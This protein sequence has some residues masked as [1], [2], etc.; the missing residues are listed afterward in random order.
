M[1]SHALYTSLL[2][3]PIIHILRAAGFH[4][5]RP[6]VLDTLVDLAARYLTVL[7]S[8]TAAHAYTNHNEL[9]PTITD[10]RMALQDVG[11]LWP[12][13]TLLEED[14]AGQEDMRG[15]EEFLA[16]MTGEEHREIR[17]IAGLEETEAGIVALK[18]KHS[19][20]GEE[21]RFQGT[22][23]GIAADEK[24]I[25]IEGGPTETIQEWSTATKLKNND[26]KASSIRKPGS[27]VVSYETSPLS[28][29]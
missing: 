3:L 16:W 28:D 26:V 22:V 21:S 12:Q 13:K 17:R 8:Q 5:T 29:V 10:V 24:P 2:R 18:K 19:R 20:T 23:L 1:S 25:R 4:A 7:A 15:I 11:A 6:A 27:S 14:I 9:S